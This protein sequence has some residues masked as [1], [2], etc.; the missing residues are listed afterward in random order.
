MARTLFFLFFLSTF[1]L[2]TGAA[3][4]PVQQVTTNSLDEEWGIIHSATSGG[5]IL[6]EDGAGT[7]VLFDGANT[8]VVQ[9]QG[10]LGGVDTVFGLGSGPVSTPEQ[11]IAVWRRSTDSG[12]ISRN[13][14]PPVPVTAVNPFAN[15]GHNAEGVAIK[16]GAVF[17]IL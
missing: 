16:D 4:F 11:V 7:V 3:T 12:W 2:M 6:W 1:H 5:K 15:V 10:N 9:L 8:N 14:A 13:G 17:M